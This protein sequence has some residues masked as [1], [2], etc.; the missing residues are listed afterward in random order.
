MAVITHVVHGH[1]HAGNALNVR[2]RAV[3]FGFDTAYWTPSI[4]DPMHLLN[5]AG[6]GANTR[7]IGEELA[8]LFLFTAAEVDAALELQEIAAE[9]AGEHRRHGTYPAETPRSV[10]AAA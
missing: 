10:L 7:Y 8:T 3:L 4:W 5:R 2:G 9:I 1:A 6:T